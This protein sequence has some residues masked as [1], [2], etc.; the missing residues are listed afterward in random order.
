MADN[1]IY[2]SNPTI[3][4]LLNWVEPDELEYQFKLIANT[5]LN[6]C[7]PLALQFVVGSEPEL[8]SGTPDFG[9]YKIYRAI[10]NLEEYCFVEVR[11]SRVRLS[12]AEF[13]AARDQLGVAM[14]DLPHSCYAIVMVGM[15]LRFFVYNPGSRNYS[16]GPKLTPIVPDGFPKERVWVL[17]E[18]SQANWIHSLF[19]RFANT[20]PS[21]MPYS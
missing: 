17:K 8:E 21:Q 10:G 11:R 15:H 4:A 9:V 18:S 6:Y 13:P 20:A 5:L 1:E 7:F 2:L 14:Q 16:Y 3:A 19:S 12:E